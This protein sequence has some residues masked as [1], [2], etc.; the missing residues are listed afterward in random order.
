MQNDH[1]QRTTGGITTEKIDFNTFQYF[2]CLISFWMYYEF[3]FNL[4]SFQI[5][6]GENPAVFRYWKGPYV[7]LRTFEPKSDAIFNRFSVSV[8]IHTLIL[9]DEKTWIEMKAHLL[10]QS[11]RICFI[12][13]EIQ[14]G[15]IS[16]KWW[17]AWRL[18]LANIY[19][20]TPIIFPFVINYTPFYLHK[21][22]KSQVNRYHPFISHRIIFECK[23]YK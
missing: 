21:D 8:V 5:L 19:P 11:K 23:Q 10:R 4:S 17:S 2:Q 12:S 22:Q 7:F 13:L 9:C 16:G 14:T 20:I 18:T 1:A 6:H 3:F 15:F